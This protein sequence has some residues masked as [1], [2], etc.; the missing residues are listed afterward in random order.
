MA[1]EGCTGA[2]VTLSTSTAT[3]A[4]VGDVSVARLR[5]ERVVTLTREPSLWNEYVARGLAAADDE[6]ARAALP[7]NVILRAM[8]MGRPSVEVASEPVEAGDLFVL[9][10]DGVRAALGDTLLASTVI[11]HR[12]D[13]HAGVRA[14]L[15]NAVANA[16][17][18]SLT[19]VMVTAGSRTSSPSAGLSMPA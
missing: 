13:L 19:V 18:G 3:I 7:S 11:A 1:C 5:A 16:A 14:L 4:W 17:L 12:H 2:G 15:E 9:A 10:S 8:G 6:K